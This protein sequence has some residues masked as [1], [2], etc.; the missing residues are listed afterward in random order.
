M[1][2]LRSIFSTLKSLVFEGLLLAIFAILIFSAVRFLADEI[3]NEFDNNQY[4]G[5]SFNIGTNYLH[6]TNFKKGKDESEVLASIEIDGSDFSFDKE[7]PCLGGGLLE[8]RE[9]NIP[10]AKYQVNSSLF[11]FKNSYHLLSLNIKS[12]QLI[13]YDSFLVI[14]FQEM[15]PVLRI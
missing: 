10:V 14:H 4:S 8:S 6:S 2:G 5:Y 11:F 3:E 12:T 7:I 1:N 9:V 15:T 13:C